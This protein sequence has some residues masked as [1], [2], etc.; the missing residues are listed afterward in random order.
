MVRIFTIVVNIY[1]LL[2]FLYW[3][4]IFAV[5]PVL[6]GIFEW[7]KYH[8]FWECNFQQQTTAQQRRSNNIWCC[9]CYFYFA[10]TLDPIPQQ[11][12]QNQFDRHNASNID[13]RRKRRTSKFS[14]I[15]KSETLLLAVFQ[16]DLCVTR[17]R[18]FSA[19]LSKD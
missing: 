3:Y 11:D 15:V 8:Y 19:A 5:T 6:A 14:A 17:Y 10:G 1:H 4:T 2:K 9:Y 13:F 7:L 18:I 12:K 16:F